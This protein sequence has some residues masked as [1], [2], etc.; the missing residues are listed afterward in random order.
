MARIN[1]W[2]EILSTFWRIA[3]IHHSIIP[4]VPPASVPV[5]KVAS[6]TGNWYMRLQISM[7]ISIF[8]SDILSILS[9]NTQV[10]I[11]FAP[12]IPY[13]VLRAPFHQTTILRPEKQRDRVQGRCANHFGVGFVECIDQRDEATNLIALLRS[14]LAGEDVKMFT[15]LGLYCIHMFIYSSIQ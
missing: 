8:V 10:P 2:M 7:S 4:H 5:F 1:E 13:G 14:Q 15:V 9:I 12:S 11:L 3:I 6:S